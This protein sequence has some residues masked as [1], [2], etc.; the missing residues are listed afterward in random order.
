MRSFIV[1]KILFLGVSLVTTLYVLFRSI[2]P[3]NKL[4][5]NFEFIINVYKQNPI[6]ATLL[7]LTF[8][9]ICWFG[10]VAVKIG[11][12]RALNLA[13]WR[14]LKCIIHSIRLWGPYKYY[15]AAILLGLAWKLDQTGFFTHFCTWTAN[16]TATIRKHNLRVILTACWLTVSSEYPPTCISLVF[17]DSTSPSGCSDSL[18]ETTLG[19]G[20][21][22]TTSL[23]QLLDLQ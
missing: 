13:K 22:S 5:S 8:F 11:F 18:D 9:G 7:T 17:S 23:W 3:N 6:L 4:H 15:V 14:C 2:P 10:A 16:I 12:L 1:S 21:L 19:T 20:S